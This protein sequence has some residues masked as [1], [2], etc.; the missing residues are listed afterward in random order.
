MLGVI[1]NVITVLLGSSIG[2][3]G[4]R[5]IPKRLTDAVMLGLGFCT[6]YI[7][8]AG[9]L[10]GQN[11]LVAIISMALGAII[12]T[13]LEIENQIV[14]LGDWVSDRFS[15]PGERS[16]AQGFV[17][18]SLLFCIGSMT[19]VGSL[20]AGLRGD[21][22]LLFTK[23]TLDFISSMMLSVSLGFGVMLAAGFVLVFQ[24]GIVA[25]SGFIAPL[26]TDAA[27]ADMTCVGS[28]LILVLGLN[29]VGI[30]KIKVS[31]YSPAI[32]IA[33]VIS[34]LFAILPGL[35]G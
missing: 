33:P 12:G 22:E 25:L 3:I 15:R 2:L 7:G 11:T 14:R 13:L 19:I 34:N 8:I 17:T 35:F 16:I 31:D 10:E 1:T 26:L 28:I 20:N 32:L 30:T 18:A 5:G 4:R 27:I 29:M 6:I 21:N 9:M 23:S 24:G